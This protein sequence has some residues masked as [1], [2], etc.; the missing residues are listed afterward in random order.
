MST[1]N[2]ARKMII[3]R[4]QHKGDCGRRKL[5]WS[6]YNLGNKL[7]NISTAC[8][9]KGVGSKYIGIPLGNFPF[10]CYPIFENG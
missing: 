7:M 10:P 5:A 1:V 2:V 9:G 3:I 6:N 8:F 4:D